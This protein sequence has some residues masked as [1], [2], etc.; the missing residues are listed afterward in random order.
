MSAARVR[1]HPVGRAFLFF[2]VMQPAKTTAGLERALGAL[3]QK[4]RMLRELALKPSRV[5]DAP[6]HERQLGQ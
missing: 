1:T 3:L 2:P 4:V 6:G 5:D